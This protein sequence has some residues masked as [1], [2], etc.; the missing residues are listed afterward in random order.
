MARTAHGEQ[1]QWIFDRTTSAFLGERTV[2]AGAGSAVL[3]KA[4]A[5]GTTAVLTKAVADRPGEVPAAS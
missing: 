3:A 5:D 1:T 2:L 4:V